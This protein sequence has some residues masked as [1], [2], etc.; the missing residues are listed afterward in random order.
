MASDIVGIA[1]N[2]YFERPVWAGNAIASVEITTPI[3][4]VSIRAT[5]FDPAE[6]QDTACEKVSV[7]V[8]VDFAALKKRFI[9]FEE[10]KSERPE[11][12]EASMIVS[13]G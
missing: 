10:V 13:G 11:L 7:S 3:K 1:E 4:V 5:E 6:R 12:T 8:D 9:K 2:G